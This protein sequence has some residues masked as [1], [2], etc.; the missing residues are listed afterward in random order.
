[1]SGFLQHRE[2]TARIPLFWKAHRWTIVAGLLG[3][4]VWA[5]GIVGTLLLAG[6]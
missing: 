2:R 1:M 4:M 3:A 6:K 5:A